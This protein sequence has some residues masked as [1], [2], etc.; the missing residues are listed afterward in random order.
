MNSF[1]GAF[2]GGLKKNRF[3]CNIKQYLEINFPKLWD[4]IYNSSCFVQDFSNNKRFLTFIL[5]EKNLI[6]E[7]IK[8][9]NSNNKDIFSSGLQKLKGCMLSINTNNHK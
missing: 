5:L 9:L 2:M 7:I 3:V 6:D 1:S 8:D 4:V